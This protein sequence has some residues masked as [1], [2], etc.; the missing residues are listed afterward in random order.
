MKKYIFFIIAIMIP[1]LASA[2]KIETDETD[3][4]TGKRTL[5]TSWEGICGQNIHLRFRLQN[6][7]QFLDFKMFVNGAVVIGEGEKLMFKST[8]DN[9]G[10]F[11]SVRMYSGTIGVGAVGISGCKNWGIS[12]SY[13]DGDFS[14]FDDNVTRLI[15]IYTT[16]VY[17]DEK[18]SESDG[19]KMIKLYKLFTS[20]LNGTV[21]DYRNLFSNYIVTYLKSTN[22]GKSWDVID[23]KYVKDMTADDI[24]S[25]MDEWK[26][27][28]SGNI[29]FECKVKKEK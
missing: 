25:I 21:G 26:A 4:F 16:D 3:E 2:M 14:Y 11:S 15:R 10:S 23:E 6:G 8:T 17:F 28:S 7:V 27:K 18:V 13:R 19:K 20:A 9:I 29:V 22:N 1:V 24:K 12:A 5:I